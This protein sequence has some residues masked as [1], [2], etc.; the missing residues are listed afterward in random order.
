[1]FYTYVLL[2]QFDNDF[3]TGSTN[4]LNRRYKEHQSGK[5]ASTKN[6]VPLLLVYYE[7]S[8]DESDCRKREKYLKSGLGRKYL[9]YRLKGFLATAT[10]CGD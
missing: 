1:M 5:V 9:R 6:R 10:K 3:Y 4:N 8:T 7:A 2:S